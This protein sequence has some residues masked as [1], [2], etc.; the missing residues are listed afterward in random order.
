MFIVYETP[1]P[2]QRRQIE[3]RPS[4]IEAKHFVTCF[5]MARGATVI[6]MEDDADNP[7]CADAYLSDGT[8]M[9]IEPEGF[10]LCAPSSQ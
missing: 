5:A 4:L 10:K 9:M 1:Q 3:R 6:M 2:L 8:L 7:G